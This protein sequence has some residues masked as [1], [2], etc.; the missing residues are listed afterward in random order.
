MVD[1]WAPLSGT[2]WMTFLILAAGIAL[3]TI[4]GVIL[5]VL[6]PEEPPDTTAEARE[7]LIAKDRRTAD[8]HRRRLDADAGRADRI[9]RDLT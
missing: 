4:I 1:I 2:D 6:T 8:L 3:L 7:R 5:L 9:T